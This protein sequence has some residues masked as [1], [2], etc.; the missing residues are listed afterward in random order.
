MKAILSSVHFQAGAFLGF[1]FTGLAFT[2]VLTQLYTSNNLLSG[3][4]FYKDGKVYVVVEKSK[5]QQQEFY[6]RRK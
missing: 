3:L 1:L 5:V 4:G 6:A 2:Y